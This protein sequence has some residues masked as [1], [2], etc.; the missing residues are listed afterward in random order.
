MIGVL[1][2][3]GQLRRRC[4]RQRAQ[5]TIADED[6]ERA[7]KKHAD[8]SARLA[9]QQRWAGLLLNR[10]R[11]MVFVHPI[12][13]DGLPGKFSDVNDMA[14]IAL[15]YT[16]EHL[17]D[18]TILDL[19]QHSSQNALS[20]KSL[21]GEGDHADDAK[22][23]ARRRIARILEY[24]YASY[25]GV[26]VAS[27]E[28][29]IPV[30]VT[31][32]LF[33]QDGQPYIVTYASDMTEH[34]ESQETLVESER[35]SEN[36]FM[37]SQLGVVVYD[38]RRKLTNINP[39]AIRMLGLPD[40]QTFARFNVFDHPFMSD[41]AREAIRRGESVRYE[42]TFDFD[43]VRRLGL[44]ETSNTGKRVLEIMMNNISKTQDHELEGC[45]VQILDVTE[46]RNTEEELRHSEK[47]LRQAQ[48]LQSIGT[49][50]GGIAHDFN[51]ILTPV[52]GYSEMAVDL[53][54]KNSTIRNY[55]IEIMRA[56][57]R[58]QELANQILTFSRQ[59]DQE[60]R[61]LRLTPIIKEVLALQRAALPATI[62]VEYSFEA[63]RDIVVSDPSQ[64]HQIMMN[65]S[66]NAVYAMKDTGGLLEV[67]V[68]D[69]IL[70]PELSIAFHDLPA[71]QYVHIAVRDTGS[72]IEK[73]AA[74]R[75]FDPFFTTKGRGEGTGM[76]LAVVH[77][78]VSTLGGNVTF[79]SNVGEGTVFNIVL[80]TVELAAEAPEEIDEELPGGQECVL[81]VDD[82]ADIVKLQSELLATFGYRPV[83]CN[84][85][86]DALK[87]YEKDPDRYD[88]VI[89]D[90]VMPV[91]SG[92]DLARQIHA[93]RPDQ[94]IIICTGFSEGFPLEDARAFGVSEVVMKPVSKGIL[95]RAIRRALDTVSA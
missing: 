26:Y 9:D 13:E 27:N 22:D 20:T 54:E 53:A 4:R 82:E 55:L 45:L 52:L 65:L 37:Y 91:M 46:Q 18:T 64:I 76:G 48:R 67:T 50:A 90:Q 62:D 80:P 35:V 84:K 10:T 31:A 56:S 15:G 7:Q 12:T 78:I 81:F 66:S 8:A 51:N 71:G 74:D 25:D 14:C 93:I 38:G 39:I 77:G 89:T 21:A 94:P 6:L 47:Q 32:H 34:Q 58:A 72:G 75:I 69:L 41:E 49:L 59:T 17:L 63:E 19:E 95:A 3:H 79:D 57:R 2:A 16:H 60:M 88:L 42:A 73:G 36:V 30:E 24:G 29:R 85:S 43:E 40:Q 92:V 83:L 86:P 23:E 5:L 87:L 1:V 33:D 11:D 70:D 61:P 28:E 68:Q 44:F